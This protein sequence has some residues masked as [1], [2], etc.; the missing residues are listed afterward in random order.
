MQARA[1]AL[2]M[3]AAILVGHGVAAILQHH[4]HAP[5]AI[6]LARI[7]A[8]AAIGDA[9]DDRHAVAELV[10]FYRD[11]RFGDIALRPAGRSEEHTS[12]LHSLMRTSYAVFCL[13]KK[14]KHKKIRTYTYNDHIY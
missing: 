2:E 7:D 13:K 6:G 3:I 12:E 4:A 14:K 1:H 5:D 11:R 9:A 8:A 10:A